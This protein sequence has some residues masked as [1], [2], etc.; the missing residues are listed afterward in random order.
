MRECN[1]HTRIHIERKSTTQS[2]KN[3]HTSHN[4]QTMRVRHFEAY[5][6]K[7]Q[8][9]KNQHL[10]NPQSKEIERGSVLLHPQR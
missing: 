5:Q 4:T 10:K 3:H 2:Y 1:T 6:S 7:Y 9:I 8:S